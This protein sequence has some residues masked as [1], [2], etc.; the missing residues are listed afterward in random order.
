MQLFSKEEALL[1]MNNYYKLSNFTY[2]INKE[3]LKGEKNFNK[4]NYK[5]PK[6]D[7][8]YFSSA[9]IDL[10]NQNFVAKDTE[11]NIHKGVFIIQK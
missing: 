8:F 9:I 5:L 3:E 6:S 10:K 11:I 4:S 2:S 1:L 7:E